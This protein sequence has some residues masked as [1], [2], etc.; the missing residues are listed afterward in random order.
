MCNEFWVC[1]Y[2]LL[3]PMY[4]NNVFLNWR[5]LNEHLSSGEVKCSDFNSKYHGFKLPK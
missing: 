1:N 2:I 5:R 3:R 4:C